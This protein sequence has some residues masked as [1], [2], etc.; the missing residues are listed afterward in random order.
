M[1]GLEKYSFE[2]GV[3]RPPSEGGSFS[4]LLR[5]TRNCPWNRCTFCGM[6]KDEKFELRHP[7]DIK[8][9][10]DAV[11][12]ICRDLREISWKIGHGGDITHEAAVALIDRTPALNYHQGFAMVYHWLMSGGRTVFLQDANSMI[13]KTDQLTEVLTYLRRTFPS[14]NRVTSYARSKTLAQKKPESLA[15]IRNA[16]LDRVH[17][18]LES[19]DDEVLRRIRKGATAEHHVVG[20]R[21]AI[22]AGF[23]VSE[24]WMPGLGGQEL[25]R[26]HA[27]HTAKVLN[28][29]NPHYIRSRP[30]RAWPGTPLNTSIMKNEVQLLSP[31][32]QLQELKLTMETL[33]VTS[34][35][36]F[37]HAGNY[38]KDRRGGYLFSHDYEG[39]Q[40]PQ[41]QGK[42]LALIEEG[43]RYSRS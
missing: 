28:E 3:Y 5:L 31:T 34:K 24:Y 27:V 1:T 12:A 23:Q 13:M 7:D 25:W 8:R 35:V 19:G 36:C 17:L 11:A 29:I 21:K 38:W 32:E 6:Y 16:G 30:F 22:A 43:I 18:G 4:L 41:E 10:I 2:T 20:G 15:R 26:Q 37:D 42:V 14:V 33:E 40:F 9:D 39:Y